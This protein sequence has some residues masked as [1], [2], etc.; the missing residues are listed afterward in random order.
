MLWWLVLWWLVLW[1]LVLWWLV[2]W[3]LKLWWLVLRWLVLLVTCAFGDLCFWWLV[4][5]ETCALVTCAFGDL[6]FDDLYFWWPVLWWL[7]LWWLVFRPYTTFV[8]DWA[9]DISPNGLTFT[10]W[11]CCGLC[12]WH[13]PTELAFS[14]F[15]LFLCLC[16]YDPFNC[17]SFHKFSRQLSAFSLCSSGL[18]FALLVLLTIRHFMKVSFSHDIILCGWLG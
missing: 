1:W 4:F 18:I 6:C 3:W 8:F 12:F 10:W 14:F 15:I 7:V 2:L 16:L 9:L 5:L 13:K 17:I 11:G